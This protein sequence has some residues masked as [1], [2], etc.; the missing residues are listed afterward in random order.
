M[1]EG[2][3]S[4]VPQIFSLICI[5]AIQCLMNFSLYTCRVNIKI[6]MPG[7]GGTCPHSQGIAELRFKFKEQYVYFYN[8]ITLGDNT[9]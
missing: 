9:L 1:G 7:K 8:I 6:L 4:I 5:G 3:S 2:Q